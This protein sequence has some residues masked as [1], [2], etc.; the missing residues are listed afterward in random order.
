MLFQLVA[1]ALVNRNV[2]QLVAWASVDSDASELADEKRS[3]S[4]DIG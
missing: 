3:V 1:L 4:C 2:F